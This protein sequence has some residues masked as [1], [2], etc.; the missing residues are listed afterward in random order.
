MDTPL[1]K[2]R[3]L[4]TFSVDQIRCA[5][6]G[7]AP[8]IIRPTAK[9]AAVAA[10]LHETASG[11]EVLFIERAEHPGDPWSGHM[12]FPGGRVDPGD[13]TPQHAAERE[14]REEVGIELASAERLGRL[15][16]VEG[17]PP[18]FDSLVVSAFVYH[19]ERRVTPTLNYEVRDAL[20]V[21]MATLLD[22]SRHVPFFWPREQREMHYPGILVGQPERHV[23]WGLTYRFVELF[24][25]ALGRPIR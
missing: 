15:D 4:E 16:D 11:T 13:A 20:W 2:L 1:P 17:A 6:A 12:A 8:R 22:S 14:T 7:H 10:V 23:V 5:L 21:P 24:F 18:G 25:T 3:A 9:H 19:L